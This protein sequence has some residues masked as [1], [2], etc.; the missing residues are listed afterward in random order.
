[1]VRRLTPSS[2]QTLISLAFFA[3]F[4]SAP[5]ATL[6]LCRVVSAAGALASAGFCSVSRAALRSRSCFSASSAAWR[7]ASS[8]WRRRSCS[9]SSASRAS[10]AAAGAAGASDAG[11]GSDSRF[12][13]MRFF[14]TSTWMVRAFPLE[15]DFLMISEVCARQ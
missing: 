11:P 5:G 2:C 8:S 7:V 10:I 13:K 6:G 9:R 12:T 14:L 1:M 15:S 4:F 3:P